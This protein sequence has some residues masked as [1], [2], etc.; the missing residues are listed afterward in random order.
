VPVGIPATAR[1]PEI[2]AIAPERSLRAMR[3]RRNLGEE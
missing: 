1:F 2:S 3:R